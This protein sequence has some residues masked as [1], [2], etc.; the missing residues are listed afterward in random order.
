LTLERLSEKIFRTIPFHWNLE[1]APIPPGFRLS[2]ASGGELKLVGCYM[3]TLKLLGRT[4]KR[5]LYVIESLTACQAILGI[6]FMREHQLVV[7]SGSPF[8]KPLSKQDLQPL[9][10]SGFQQGL[11]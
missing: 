5:P 7:D 2:S 1:S 8:F 3:F 4:I 11:F 9:L 10:I 6:D